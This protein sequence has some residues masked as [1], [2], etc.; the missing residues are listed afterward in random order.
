MLKVWKEHYFEDFLEMFHDKNL[1]QKKAEELVN[2]CLKPAILDYVTK[3]TGSDVAQKLKERIGLQDDAIPGALHYSILK[4]LVSELDY[5]KYQQYIHHCNI[6]VNNWLLEHIDEQFF[7]DGYLSKIENQHL[8]EIIK[9]IIAELTNVRHSIGTAEEIVSFVYCLYSALSQKLRL[10]FPQ[11]ALNSVMIGGITYKE[12]FGDH[13]TTYVNKMEKILTEPYQTKADI[14]ERIRCVLF[15]TKHSNTLLGCLEQC[16]FCKAPCEARDGNHDQH[17]S[18]AHRPQGLCGLKASKTLMIEIC[19]NPTWKGS[20][21]KTSTK[22]RPHPRKTPHCSQLTDYWRY[23]M[24][25]LNERIAKDFGVLP[26]EI[27]E[28]WRS[29]TRRDALNCLDR[30]MKKCDL[31]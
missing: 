21:S 29:L 12:E 22:Q 15:K 6:F 10:L 17:F 14:K 26:A 4:E 13:F 24:V 31:P 5:N 3:S 30:A 8:M 23:V 1:C 18:S 25:T 2:L 27:P 7:K 11:N 16:P 20:N 28:S 9:K 19:S